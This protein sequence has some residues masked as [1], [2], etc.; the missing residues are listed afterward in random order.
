MRYPGHELLLFRD[1]RTWKRYFSGVLMSYVQGDVLEVGC[2]IGANA[3]HLINARVRSWT[4]LEPDAELLG[5]VP[6]N[7]VSPMLLSAERIVGTIAAVHGRAFDSILY[8]DVI[9]HIHDA[10]AELRQAYEV[11]R[12]GG[13]LLILVPA[14]NMLFSPFDRA[15]GH[16]RRYTKRSLR[17]EIPAEAQLVHMR[18]LDSMGA[19]LSLS[20]KVLLRSAAPT[21]AQVRFWDRRIVP[22][23]RLLDPVVAYG[24]GKSLV[25]VARKP[26]R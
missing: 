1:A 23:S 12:P 13:H 6:G 21:A 25:A 18:Y 19:L 20:N 4:F 8:L 22:L 14:F 17:Q 3:D 26:L 7:I 2:G 24:L 11:L 15:I 5:Q 16:Y 10:R 9:E